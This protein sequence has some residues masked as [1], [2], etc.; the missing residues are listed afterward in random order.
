MSLGV[1]GTRSNAQGE[2]AGLDFYQLDTCFL[3]K[4]FGFGVFFLS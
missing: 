3:K 2:F 1:Q 4:F